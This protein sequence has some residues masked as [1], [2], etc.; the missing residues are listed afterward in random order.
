M[1]ALV[2]STTRSDAVSK[3]QA[4]TPD[5]EQRLLALGYVSGVSA[6]NL[7]DRRRGDPKETVALYNLLLLAGEDS[8]GWEIMGGVAYRFGKVWSGVVGYRFL[9]E[10]YAKRRFTYF[11]DVSGFVLGVSFRF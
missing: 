5:V 7:E 4:V 2:A 10:E 1:R 3:P 9:H 6:K 8:E 11:T